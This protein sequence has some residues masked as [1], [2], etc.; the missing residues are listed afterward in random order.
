[1]FGHL[2]PPGVYRELQIMANLLDPPRL[3]GLKIFITHIKESLIPH[4]TGRSA[5]ERI[6]TELYLLESTSKLGVQFIE[7]KQGDRICE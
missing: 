6:M 2:S 3:D 1:M 7:A 5:K 4:P